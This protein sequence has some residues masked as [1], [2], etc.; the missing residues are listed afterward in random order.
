[1]SDTETKSL[2]EMLD[3]VQKKSINLM[4]SKL[5]DVMNENDAGRLPIG[6]ILS[7]L[8]SFAITVISNEANHSKESM[9]ELIELF[10]EGTLKFHDMTE[11][12]GILKIDGK[13]V[14]T[15]SRVQNDDKTQH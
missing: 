4:V 6:T 3:D 8:S 10:C 13:V 2:K 1:M 14:G 12:K 9:K 7:I 11:E 15:V 5:V